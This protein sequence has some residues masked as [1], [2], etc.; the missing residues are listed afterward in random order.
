MS[1]FTAAEVDKIAHL[2]ECRRAVKLGPWYAE[3]REG[4]IVLSPQTVKSM[5]S[6]KSLE[7]IDTLNRQKLCNSCQRL[8][9]YHRFHYVTWKTQGFVWPY[10]AP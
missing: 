3:A 6:T 5:Q 10:V 7:M 1:V 4:K 2:S 8:F 9:N